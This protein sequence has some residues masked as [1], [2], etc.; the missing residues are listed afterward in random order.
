MLTIIPNYSA[1]A[2]TRLD[3]SALLD[4]SSSLGG[5]TAPINFG[6]FL[7]ADFPA[8][9]TGK[10]SA[11]VMIP[12][13][14]QH[15]LTYQYAVQAVSSTGVINPIAA[16]PTGTFT[17]QLP[18]AKPLSG[19]AYTRNASGITPAAATTRTTGGGGAGT[20][21]SYTYI[22][23]S[24]TLPANEPNYQGT[25]FV[26][27]DST[28][29]IW[30]ESQPFAGTSATLIFPTPAA[31]GVY[32]VYACGYDGTNVNP[33][34]PGITP[35]FTITIGTNGGV[36][37]ATQIPTGSGVSGASG[38]LAM[39]YGFG[40]TDDGAGNATIKLPTA[41]PFS[42]I[43]AGLL[44][45]LSTDF[46]V[47]TS[48][49]NA[50]KITQNAVNL[51]NAYGFNTTNFTTGGGTSLA[52]NSIAVS[53]LIAG[54]TFNLGT[55]VFAS[56]TTG[57]Y[58]AMGSTGLVMADSFT[59]PLNSIAISSFGL[60]LA[61]YNSSHG[62]WS[63]G[64][65]YSAGSIV[66]FQNFN[67]ISLI[68]GNI[69]NT[70]TVVSADWQLVG[71]SITANGIG[72]YG[73]SGSLTATSAGIAITNGTASVL[74][75]AAGVAITN[76][77]LTCT[78]NS[79]TTTINNN[80]FG[81]YSAAGLVSFAGSGTTQQSVVAGPGICGVFV[82]GPS[83]PAA[84]AQ[85]ISI[86]TGSVWSG[87]LGLKDGNGNQGQMNPGTLFLQNSAATALL[88]TGTLQFNGTQVLT[89]RS[90]GTPATL[91]DVIAVLQHHG[92]SN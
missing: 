67:Y 73:V 20:G 16:S 91:A 14:T 64:T 26:V 76:G 78:A 22:P 83:S 70:P 65:N 40:L 15:P 29:A 19:V 23:V 77:T 51:A 45:N 4:G 87:E 25:I 44:L 63:A 59:T 36:V 84:Y 3:G 47:P 30:F 82:G 27:V 52:V 92:L 31:V 80:S 2:V 89:T 1:A 56:S 48:G 32:T 71:L 35:S 39:K 90:P 68:S 10:Q 85:F 42:V 53:T 88:N 75:A 6:P 72:I 54:N 33:V 58:L 57:A 13:P 79:T 69:G 41:T 62:T 46:V 17:L 8:D 11:S 60:S 28:G 38:A 37:D 61:Q 21:T 55:S 74:V 50:G 7:L 86:F 9:A 12:E 81:P 24:W 34:V 5:A 18:V 43:A 49:P 66:S